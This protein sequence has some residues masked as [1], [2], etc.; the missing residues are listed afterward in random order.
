MGIEN[1]YNGRIV[2]VDL[3]TGQCEEEAL[4]EE[5]I[6]DRLGGPG[7]NMVLFNRYA[8]RDPIIVGTG[9]LTGTF[10]PS[11]CLGVIT[12]KSPLNGSVC[13]APL[14]WQTGIE[15]KLTGFDFLVILGKS[16]KPVR[17]WFHDEL[18]DLEDSSEV[19]GRDTWETTDYLRKEHGDDFV[20]ALVIG[21]AGENQVKLAQVSENYWGSKEKVGFGS[22]FG[23]KNLKAIALRGLGAL[24]VADGF[25]E[26]CNQLTSK[27]KQGIIM[28]K[29]GVKDILLSLEI[30][31][32]IQDTLASL[33]HRNAS[34]F[35]CSYPCNT[36]LKYREAPTVLQSEGAEEE[37]GTL[38]SDPAGFIAFSQLC[39]HDSPKALERAYRLGL[40]PTSSAMLIGQTGKTEIDQILKE[41]EG[42]AI[43]SSTLEEADLPNFYGLSPWPFESS[44]ERSLVQAFG[45]F[46][47]S[48]PPGPVIAHFEDFGVG[49][50][51]VDRA[52]WWI[53]RQGLAYILGIC[54]L[55]AIMAP[56]LTQE[57]LIELVKLSSGWEDFDQTRLQNTITQMIKE[58]IEAGEKLG[59]V[60]ESLKTEKFDSQLKELQ[61]KL[62]KV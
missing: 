18:A 36:F 3:E 9:L 12:A 20:Q 44:P 61:E 46:S 49:E 58:T 2:V 5:L 60:S 26:A 50:S 47:N 42:L 52:Q 19:W 23:Q 28:G 56:E 40:E 22:L 30:D 55:F 7:I 41:L 62:V 4:E 57:K 38:I 11:S 48:I 10:C 16:E 6:Q 54:P 27:I 25:F 13:H 17:L 32:G 37:P 34:C 59:Q 33:T 51:P 1:M 39:G 15:L 43:T 53:R 14:T 45:I 35:N 8:D 31:E 24:E 29:A 21:P